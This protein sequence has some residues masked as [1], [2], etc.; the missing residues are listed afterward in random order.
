M[1]YFKRTSSLM[2]ERSFMKLSNVVMDENAPRS[3]NVVSSGFLCST[4]IVRSGGTEHGQRSGVEHTTESAAPERRSVHC[5]AARL[6]NPLSDE[7]VPRPLR[8]SIFW[9][10]FRRLSP[11]ATADG[12]FSC[13]RVNTKILRRSSECHRRLGTLIPSGFRGDPAPGSGPASYGLTDVV[14]RPIRGSEPS[15]PGGERSRREITQPRMGSRLVVVAPP[16]MPAPSSRR[17]APRTNAG[18]GTRRE[19]GR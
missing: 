8:T 9:E 13:G 6:V 7:H 18:S 1:V 14:R 3:V 16:S 15:N 19:V 4:V 11:P 17:Q 10:P 5:S 2:P 12:S